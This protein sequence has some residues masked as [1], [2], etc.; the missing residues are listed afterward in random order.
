MSSKIEFMNYCTDC[1]YSNRCNKCIECNL[2]N[3]C[4]ESENCDFCN[5]CYKCKN[6]FDSDYC[7]ESINLYHCI[8]CHQCSNLSFSKNLKNYHL[9]DIILL[10]LIN[11]IDIYFYLR[12]YDIASKEKNPL[13]SK[14]ILDDCILEIL[15]GFNIEI[16]NKHYTRGYIRNCINEEIN[17]NKYEIRLIFTKSLLNFKGVVYELI[18][19]QKI[20]YKIFPVELFFLF[21][22]IV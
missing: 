1:K 20:D 10:E 12:L 19:N 8:N 11:K 7:T 21:T 17:N 15:K 16:E 3:D 18:R 13:Y 22:E 5:F 2:C 9:S 6:C 14:F 4:T